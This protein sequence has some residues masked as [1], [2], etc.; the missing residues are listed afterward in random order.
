MST[1][2]TP[3]AETQ[4]GR[5]FLASLGICVALLGLLFVWLLG[6]SF[7]RAWEMRSWPEVSCVILSAEII[8]QRHDEFSPVE[9][10]QNLSY[11]YE[12]QGESFTGTRI[13]LRENPWTSKRELMEEREKEYTAGMVTSCRLDPAMPERAVLKM[14]SLAPGYSIWFPGL[15]VVGGLGITVRALRKH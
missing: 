4:A 10:Q 9:F 13:T 7:L 12:W 2:T 1:S 14:D 15:F 3:D 11:A 6:R 8:E 5:W